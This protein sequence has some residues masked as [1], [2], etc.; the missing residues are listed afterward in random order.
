MFEAQTKLDLLQSPEYTSYVNLLSNH[1]G[2]KIEVINKEIKTQGKT[3]TLPEF[4]NIQDIMS[5]LKKE[6][7]VLMKKLHIIYNKILHSKQED[8]F[9]YKE[10]YESLLER[11]N[12]IEFE[13]KEIVLF[14][15]RQVKINDLEVQLSKL[16]TEKLFYSQKV[17]ILQ[18]RLRNNK[19][20]KDEEEYNKVRDILKEKKDE[21]NKVHSLLMQ[22]NHN[23]YEVITKLPSF[24]DNKEEIIKPNKK[25]PKPKQKKVKT[26]EKKKSLSPEQ[27]KSILVNNKNQIMDKFRFKTKEEC[28]SRKAAVFMSKEEIIKVIE[29]N[30]SLKKAMPAK[31]KTLSK[32]KICEF[33]FS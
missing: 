12:N 11:I 13:M 10:E 2:I 32:E 7:S 27:V 29:E 28:L 20:S 23:N 26:P 30:E 24:A 9:L 14:L 17:E 31:Y 6:K 3:V 4:E 22:Y 18:N 1:P 25:E 8:H 5:R 19:S 21:V 33:L 15:D 16:E